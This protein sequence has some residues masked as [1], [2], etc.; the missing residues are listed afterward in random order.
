L[1]FVCS[2]PQPSAAGWLRGVCATAA[3]LTANGFV[4]MAQIECYINAGGMLRRWLAASPPPA[5]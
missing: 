1:P 4:V 5:Q 2:A 3:A